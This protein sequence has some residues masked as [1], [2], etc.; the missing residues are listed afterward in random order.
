MKKR[1]QLKLLTDRLR[2]A[3]KERSK[4]RLGME[5]E[6]L[7]LKRNSLEAVTYYEDG[8]IEDI[9][10]QMVQLSGSNW[11]PVHE[12]NHVIGLEGERG[13][14]TLEP[15]GQLEFS[16]EPGGDLSRIDRAYRSFL[17]D[18]LPSLGEDK[19]LAASGFQPSS[20]I[21][22]IPLL[23]KERY[24][25]MYQYFDGKGLAHYMMKGSAALHVTI[26]FADERDYGRK[27]KAAN[28]LVPI[29]YSRLDNAPF[30][31]GQVRRGNSVR[32][33]IWTDCTGVQTGL[34]P[35]ALADGFSYEDYCQ[36]LL[37]SPL[38]LFKRKGEIRSGEGRSMA[39]VLTELKRG[40]LKEEDVE[41]L[42][43]MVF[44]EVRTRGYLEIRSCDSLPYPYNIGY[45]AFWKGL[46]YD[47]ENL[48]FLNQ[49]G[50][51]TFAQA[52]GFELAPHDH[53]ALEKVL[54]QASGVEESEELFRQLLER[55]FQG[56]GARER[57]YL[58]PLERLT[59]G[60][61]P[62]DLALDRLAAEG[63]ES[64][65][66]HF[67]PRLSKAGSKQ[68]DR[69]EKQSLSLCSCCCSCSCS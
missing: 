56:L 61:R 13:Y 52:E 26:D 3:E 6:H 25:H 65:V 64:L 17:S 45:L 22:E 28:L 59:R 38:I 30:F 14:V 51:R 36:F 33:K 47:E 15:G 1:A 68:N 7:V 48:R 24:A 57:T 11:K 21:E 32:R 10:A 16:T 37:R 53:S 60:G 29:I 34:I 27:M 39:E 20:A 69:S 31:Q 50:D 66:D 35:K 54:K 4:F 12:E 42:F 8:G 9:L 41:Y 62:K 19:I 43:S 5:M 40:E 44:P 67:S 49:L 23:P 18:I 55:S 46:L 2:R 58:R 63:L